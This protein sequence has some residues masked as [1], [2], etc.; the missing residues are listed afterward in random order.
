MLS[1]GR[2]VNVEPLWVVKWVESS[3]SALLAK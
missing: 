3:V 1:L 2:K